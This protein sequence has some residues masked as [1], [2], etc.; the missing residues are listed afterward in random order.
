MRTTLTLDPDVAE[1]L[2][3]ELAISKKPFKAVLNDALRRGL[4]IDPAPRRKRFRVHAHSSPFVPGIDL[5][6]LNQAVDKLEVLE[7]QR[8]HGKPE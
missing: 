6:R 2:K 8:R 7:F 1:R 3:Q 4:G 5:G